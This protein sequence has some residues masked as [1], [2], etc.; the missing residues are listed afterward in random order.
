MSKPF[1]GVVNVDVLRAGGPPCADRR[2]V[3]AQGDQGRLAPLRAQLLPPLPAGRAP[4][5]GDRHL[6]GAHRLP[7]RGSRGRLEQTSDVV[8]DRGHGPNAAVDHEADVEAMLVADHGELEHVPEVERF[9]ELQT[10]A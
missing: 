3:P 8:V 9:P 5:R 7:L 10:R 2:A 6:D 1:K 4:G